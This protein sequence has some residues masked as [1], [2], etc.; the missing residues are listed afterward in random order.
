MMQRGR[1]TKRT[2]VE[3]LKRKPSAA[4]AVFRV[5][6]YTT[7]T[8]FSLQI[9]PSAAASMCANLTGLSL[10]QTKITL[11][12]S[13]RAGEMVSGVTK[14][15]VGLCR[16]AGT[17]KPSSDSNIKFEVW[18]P[19]NGRWNGKYEQIGNG[20]FA[21]TIWVSYIADAVSRGYAAAATDDGTSGPPLGAATFIGHPDVLK[22]FGYRAVKITT[23]NSKAI[24]KRLT[25]K[26]PSYSYFSGC[27]DGGREALMEAQ[28]YPNDFDGI[29]VGSPANDLAGLGASFLWNMQ[30]L[31]AGPQTHGVPDAYIPAKKIVL[32]STLALSKC[33]GKDGGVSSDAFLNDPTICHFDPAVAQCTTGQ[34]PDMCVTPAQV[35]AVKKLYSG[36]HNLAGELLFPGYEPGSGANTMNWPE[37]LV[38]TSSTSPGSQ[39]AMTAAFW[40][41]AVLGKPTC[42]FLGLGG[43]FEASTQSIALMANS[44][45]PD[46]AQFRSRGGKLIQYAGW[47]D[48]AIAP[49]NG[50]NYYRKVTSVMGDV[51]DFYRVFMAPGMAHCYGGLGPNSFGNGDNHGPVI[52][53][54]HDLLKALETWVERGGAPDKIIATKYFNDD[55][56][57]G[58]ALQRP[59]CP[60]PQISRYDGRGRTWDETSFECLTGK[61]HDDPRNRGLQDAY[62]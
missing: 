42:P 38:G 4:G 27:S 12:R 34:D 6:T 37:W 59:L 28:R 5:L 24:I 15:P 1:D 7:L 56:A 9:G 39:Y 46:L 36:P 53:A 41:N 11:A 45:D 35:E 3:R 13:Y 55:P 21:G 29:I 58:V 22:D 48:T 23:D 16:V 18:V 17:S 51:H 32:L 61:G 25:G 54:K 10:P 43:E 60:Y 62:R 19:T 8:S 2:I 31:L 20:G 30:A 26:N 50:L 33:V 47:A 49:E 14:A 57:K 52:D 44:T 40:C